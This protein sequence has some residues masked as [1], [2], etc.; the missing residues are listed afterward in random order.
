MFRK[1]LSAIGLCLVLSAHPVLAHEPFSPA[2]P[3]CKSANEFRTP[4][5]I[6]KPN[7]MHDKLSSEPPAGNGR[8]V[9]VDVFAE[10]DD[11]HCANALDNEYYAFTTPARRKTAGLEVN[12]RGPAQ[13][14]GFGAMCSLSG[15]YV[16]EVADHDGKRQTNLRPVDKFDVMSSGDFCLGRWTNA[17]PKPA[18]PHEKMD[19][20]ARLPVC[21]SSNEER[22]PIS[23][24]N[25][26][27]E[28]NGW[29]QD[30]SSEPPVGDGRIV[31]ISIKLPPGKPC[32]WY[33]QDLF[34]F[35]FP[36]DR[37]QRD[38]GGLEVNLRG[39][40]SD[41]DGR[42]TLEGFYMN[43]EVPGVQQGWVSTYFGAVDEKKVVASG[44]YCLAPQSDGD[45]SLR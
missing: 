42:C 9:Y 28:G 6:W 27:I 3:R 17:A 12:I 35:Y 1:Q 33:S 44:T 5:P 29:I 18:R 30:V 10:D 41:K 21:N 37:A 23:D 32:A 43:E 40:T 19:H 26:G 22:V 25:P 31:H 14:V 4:M 39:N 15:F 34:S 2:L 11:V 36:S 20:P 8:V 7:V 38:H 16:S 45:G 24:W 13:Y